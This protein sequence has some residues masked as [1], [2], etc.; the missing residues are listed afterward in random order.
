[1]TPELRAARERL[2]RFADPSASAFPPLDLGTSIT[3]AEVKRLVAQIGDGVRDTLAPDI[4][5]VVAALDAALPTRYDPPERGPAEP[6]LCGRYSRGHRIG[7]ILGPCIKTPGHAGDWHLDASGAAWDPD[8][9]Q[10]E[11]NRP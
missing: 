5:L 1:V 3:T 10:R 7:G 6:A 9:D 4:R 2:L 8:T 11:A